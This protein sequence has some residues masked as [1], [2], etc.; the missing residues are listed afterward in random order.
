MAKR[1]KY[2]YNKME[3]K[4]FTIHAIEE[5]SRI[6]LRF[7]D[8]FS[9]FPFPISNLSQVILKACSDTVNCPKIHFFP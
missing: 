7:Q 4:L 9:I 3:N 8:I 6:V 2:T 1:E 5:S